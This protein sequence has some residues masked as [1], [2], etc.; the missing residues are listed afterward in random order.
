MTGHA[1]ASTVRTPPNLAAH[2]A[3]GVGTY[4]ARRVQDRIIYN[5]GVFIIEIASAFSVMTA[6]NLSLH[7]FGP[8]WLGVLAGALAA[9]LSST[10][11]ALVAVHILGRRMR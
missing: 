9:P 4:L 2:L 3:A 8:P 1:G 10:L 5:S 11:L 6:L 7:G